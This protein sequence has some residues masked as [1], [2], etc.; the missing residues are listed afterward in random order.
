MDANEAERNMQRERLPVFI[1]AVFKLSRVDSIQ[2]AKAVAFSEELN[3]ARYPAIMMAQIVRSQVASFSP[4]CSL[5][6]ISQDP[7]LTHP[8]QRE[9][10][11]PFFTRPRPSW[12]PRSSHPQRDRVSHHHRRPSCPRPRRPSG[13]SGSSRPAFVERLMS[14]GRAG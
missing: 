4:F 9:A 5:F 13:G 1:M 3:C 2:P 14:L 12:R 8:Q 11:L 6:S 7:F 10:I